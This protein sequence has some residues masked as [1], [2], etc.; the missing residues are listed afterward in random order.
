MGHLFV[1]I[2]IVEYAIIVAAYVWQKD[3]ARVCYFIGAIV[4][5]VG[6]LNMK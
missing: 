5:S 1:K 4:L 2:L 6:V 3:W